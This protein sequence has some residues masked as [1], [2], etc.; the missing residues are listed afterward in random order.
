MSQLGQKRKLTST[1]IV[2]KYKILKEIDKG[3]S[4]SSTAVKYGIPKQTVSN[5]IKKKKKIYEAIDSN[6]STK[7]RHRFKA[8]TYENLDQACYK[9]FINA[10]A[11]NIPVSAS[12]LKTKALF[13]AKELGM[14]DFTGSDGWLDRWKKRKNVSFK[15]IS[16]N[17]LNMFLKLFVQN[18]YVQT[19][20]FEH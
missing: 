16:G 7:K 8:S 2:D 1:T 17:F 11:Q 18:I 19:L 10:R 3:N 15:T 14:T 9:W 13:F 12:V 5:W 20:S 6:L 4:L